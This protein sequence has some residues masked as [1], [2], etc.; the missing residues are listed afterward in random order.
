MGWKLDV[1]QVALS[2]KST[3]VGLCILALAAERGIHFDA[4]GHLAMSARDWFD[5]GCGALTAVVS[6]LS[7]DAGRVRAR[8]SGAQNVEMVPSHEVPDAAE[9]VPVVEGRQ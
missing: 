6:G 4:A 3:V 7:Q 8:V 5:V 1:A 9:A 2:P